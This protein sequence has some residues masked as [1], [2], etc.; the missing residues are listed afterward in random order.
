MIDITE[1]IELIKK[2]C[3]IAS[4][5][6]HEQEKAKFIYDWFSSYGIESK[7]DE[8]NNVIVEVGADNS[9]DLV[10]FAAHIDTVFPDEIGFDCIIEGNHLS[11]P[12]V[13]DDTANVAE[14]M[15]IA[16][17]LIHENKQCHRGCLFVFDSGEEGLGNLYG[18]RHLFESYKDR[19]TE[20][21]SFD[22]GYDHVVNKA[23]GS[24]RFEVKIL[25]EGGHSYGAF[26]NKNAIA[27]ASE[28]IASLYQYQVPTR[29]KSTYNVGQISG[30][31]SVNTIAQEVSFLFE[32]RSDDKNDLDE[33]IETF[34]EKLDDYRNED[35]KIELQ[36]LG[37][38]PC[39]SDVDVVKMDQI[40]QRVSQIIELNTN[41]K[42]EFVSGSTDCNI[43]Y[44]LGVAGCCFGGY[45]G[46]G[47]HTRQEYLE[48]DSLGIGMK[49]ISEYIDHFFN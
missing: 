15:L 5:S 33:M 38:R 12:G 3:S 9:S 16:R 25:T 39:M 21:Y 18:I 19:I 6:H 46:Y 28:L 36:V 2:L 26:G 45:L 11:A 8:C 41:K 27:V 48:I 49:I 44:S 47:A 7:I 23:V 42:P 40:M 10:V 35:V 29:G 20:F 30:G 37:K 1:L 34:M 24:V 32:V 43:A 17:K 4:F 13:G 14:L 22:G 31:T